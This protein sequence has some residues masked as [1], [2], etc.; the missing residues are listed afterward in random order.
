MGIVV[1]SAGLQLVQ[2]CCHFQART[3]KKKPRRIVREII[4][5]N[6]VISLLKSLFIC[7]IGFWQY[8]WWGTCYKNASRLTFSTQAV[9]HPS[10][11]PPRL[12]RKSTNSWTANIGSPNPWHHSSMT[13]IGVSEHSKTFSINQLLKSLLNCSKISPKT[14]WI[15]PL[16]SWASRTF[17]IKATFQRQGDFISKC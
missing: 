5:W 7:W 17:L 2:I 8:N 4:F 14:L 6:N 9:T 11:I 13:L 12:L 10:F 3:C 16:C 15:F 1:H